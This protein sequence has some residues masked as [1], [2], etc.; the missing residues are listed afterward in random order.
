MCS[1]T[2]S[3]RTRA[4]SA[5]RRLVDYDP[6]GAR[7]PKRSMSRILYFDCFS[8]AS[9]DMV[10]G[11]LLDLGLPLD[12]LRQALGSLAIEYGEVSSERVL[13][14]GVAATRFLA[15]ADPASHVSGHGHSHDDAHADHQHDLG[16]SPQPGRGRTTTH[17]HA[18]KDHH[19]LSDIT[20]AIGRSALSAAGKA[21]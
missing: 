21:R 3:W 4:T 19:R 12:G 10:L 17:A 2:S 18:Q 13:R 8:G 15:T 5:S 9:G 11:A 1:I 16:P 7:I 14:A 6:P 20:A